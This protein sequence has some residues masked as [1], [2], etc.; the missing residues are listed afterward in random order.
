MH[1][2]SLL[3]NAIPEAQIF[4]IFNCKIYMYVYNK[5]LDVLQERKMN[6]QWNPIYEVL[7]S[8]DEVFNLLG[9]D[10]TSWVVGSR[11]FEKMQSVL[12]KY[13]DPCRLNHYAV[14]KL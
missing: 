3:P 13:F 9:C 14:S 7:G 6:Q 11:H 5:D 2:L 10:A 8:L 12:L 4:H 1:S